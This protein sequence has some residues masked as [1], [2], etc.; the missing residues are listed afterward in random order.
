MCLTIFSSISVLCSIRNMAEKW[1]SLFTIINY[2]SLILVTTSLHLVRIN[3]VYNHFCFPN[4]STEFLHCFF[5]LESLKENLP[6]TKAGF[7][8]DGI[9]LHFLKINEMLISFCMLY[10]LRQWVEYSHDTLWN[11]IFCIHQIPSPISPSE[12]QISTNLK[13]KIGRN[14]K[15]NVSHI[16]DSQW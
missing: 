3:M 8:I 13:K 2:Q 16:T 5:I 12:A 7:L 4:I 10:I 11:F 9:A 6:E 14:N 15:L 1:T